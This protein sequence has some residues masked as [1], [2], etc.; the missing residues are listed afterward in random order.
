MINRLERIFNTYKFP[1]HNE[2]ALQQAIED[3]LIKEKIAYSR[4]F[5]LDA[6]NIPDF[7]LETK[8]G[9]IAIEVKL[10]ANKKAIYRQLERYAG[11]KGVEQLILVTNTAMGLPETINGK[12]IYFFSLGKLWL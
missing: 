2:K 9:V 5:K 10:K 3:A 8:E 12:P 1:L 4:E 6:K 11:F 7:V